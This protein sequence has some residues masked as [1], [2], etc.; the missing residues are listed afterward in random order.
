LAAQ[1]YAVLDWRVLAFMAAA[2]AITGVIFGVLPALAI[3]R[4]Q[5]VQEII[6]SQPGRAGSG[7]GWIRSVLVAMQAALTVALLA[8]CIVMMRSFLRLLNA[9]LGFKPGHVVTMRASV[10]GMYDK[11]R[12][13]R[14]YNAALDRLRATPG[15]EAAG[16]VRYLPL[17]DGDWQYLATNL[18][19]ESAESVSGHVVPNTIT[20]GYFQAMGI[21]FVAGRDFTPEEYAGR[22]HVVIVD[23]SFA[24]QSGL[25]K[26][27]V[28]RQGT[29]GK[30]PYTIVGVVRDTWLGGPASDPN[31]LI[32]EPLD[33][34][35]APGYVNLVARVHGPAGAYLRACRAALQEIDPQIPIYD[36]LSLDQRLGSN[37]LQ[38]RFYTTTILM[39]SVFALLLAVIGVY[40]VATYSVTQRTHEIGIRIAVGATPGKVRAAILRQGIVPVIAGVCLGIAG[41]IGSGKLLQSLMA[42]AEPLRLQTCVMG[43]LL[44]TATAVAAIW[45][46][47]SRVIRIDPMTALKSE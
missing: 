47:T 28:G 26:A 40:G 23:E 30:V 5:P 29:R 27:I 44:L 6:H 37:L 4:A 2:T 45:R 7:T 24:R 16:A 19:I 38:P 46:A 8:G 1:S 39:V 9:D 15:V 14:Y 35:S 43:G 21:D 3:R 10:A 33:A 32:Y 31:M 11:D 22:D 36:E 17:I 13:L 20:S 12:E 42:S 34:E 18:K 41:A 25:G